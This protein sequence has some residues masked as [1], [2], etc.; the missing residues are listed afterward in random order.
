MLRR[1]NWLFVTALTLSQIAQAQSVS[2]LIEQGH[3]KRAEAALR[4][5]LQQ[6]P[7]DANANYLRSKVDA[8]FG[9]FDEAI[10]CAEKAVSADN[11][12]PEYHAQLAD[13]VGAKADDP[14]VGMF[15]KL[16]LAKRVRQE[17][18]LALKTD[19]KNS[20]ANSDLLDFFL[21]AP[22]FAGGSKD[23]AKELAEHVTQ[24]DPA[25]GYLLQV[26]FARHE[27]Q[28]SEIE[29]L[30]RRAI[31]A[32]PNNYDAHVGLADFYLSNRS[33]QLS[34]AEEL[35]RES[36]KLEPQRGIAY[37]ILT[38]VAARQG[39]W[40]DVERV[41]AESEKSVPD[42]LAPYYQ[43][44]R[45]ILISGSGSELSRAE[46]YLR[47]YLSQEPEAGSPPLSAAHWRL[48]LVLEK[49]GRKDDARAELQAALKLQP[50]FKE[51][52]QDL[53]RLR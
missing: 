29:Q 1:L 49:E 30:Y 22:G 37:V 24:I 15:Q 51:A 38:V 48:G 19:P 28:A 14:K 50:D 7:N 42:N 36:V 41:L 27:K 32:A 47:K 3:Y 5:Q 12:R 21:D 2:D 40:P 44:A 26:Q 34:R 46:S 23:K 35:A 8:A 45:T 43:A 9:R 52:Q 11:V 13:A 17:A 33:P 10:S 39:R 20:E 4:V 25:Q 31:Q 53:K 16:S 18:E 6:N